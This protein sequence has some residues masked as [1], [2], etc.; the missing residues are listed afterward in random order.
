MR[1]FSFVSDKF[2]TW[3][4][5]CLAPSTVTVYR[6]YFR[7]FV[8]YHGDLPIAKLKPMHLQEWADTWHSAQAIKRLF[9]WA[10]LDAGLVT[11]NPF[12][13]CKQPPKGQRRRIMSGREMASYLRLTKPDLR[14]LLLLHRETFARPEELRLAC[15]S[16][17]RWENESLSMRSALLAGQ[18]CI[19]L[20][21][22]K[23]RKRRRLATAPRVILVSPRA[24]RLLVRLLDRAVS[25]DGK[26]LQ[27][28]AGRAWTPNAVRCRLRRIRRRFAL[29]RDKRGE[30]VV[31]YTFRH[32]GATA[33]SAAGIR[34]RLLADILGHVETA[35]TARYQHLALEHLRT[36]LEPLW[37]RRKETPKIR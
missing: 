25:S 2:L 4:A 13:R 29:P 23:A 37:S 26:I 16:D 9:N 3:A 30:N 15:W 10:L 19:V 11:V 35:T 18:A 12:L 33:A 34:D 20:T 1:K 14:A 6:H 32:S 22:Y 21:D 7:R 36:A 24:G 8:E 17:V 27:T 5:K 31:P 28:A